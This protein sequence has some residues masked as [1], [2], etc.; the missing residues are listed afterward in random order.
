MI[1]GAVWWSFM[2][3]RYMN[4]GLYHHPPHITLHYP[5]LVEHLVFFQ[6]F[7]KNI[8]SFLQIFIAFTT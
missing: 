6:V 4:A 2:A 1:L 3:C 8:P 7:E 5:I